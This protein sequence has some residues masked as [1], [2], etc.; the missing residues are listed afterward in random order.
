MRAPVRMPQYS[1]ASWKG[2]IL[3]HQY[4]QWYKVETLIKMLRNI[5][6][7]NFSIVEKRAQALTQ[8]NNLI[9]DAPFDQMQRFPD[10]VAYISLAHGDWVRKIQQLRTSLSLK[11][12]SKDKKSR[13]GSTIETSDF[14]DSMIAF[15][16]SI[17]N[18]LTQLSQQENIFTRASF[19]SYYS[20]EW[21][22]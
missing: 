4:M 16:N 1:E 10:R 12:H 2:A 21:Q 9:D 20:L 5:W 6:K 3:T 18:L 13:S 19:E 17:T 8:L 15:H 22:N 7:I 14:G 11:K